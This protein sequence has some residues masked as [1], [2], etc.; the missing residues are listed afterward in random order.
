MGNCTN[1]RDYEM[2]SATEQSRRLRKLE[3]CISLLEDKLDS[4]KLKESTGC[5]M[6]VER[7]VVADANGNMTELV[8]SFL[9]GTFVSFASILHDVRQSL[10]DVSNRPKKMFGHETKAL[11]QDMHDASCDAAGG[12]QK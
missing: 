1:A 6:E 9:W 12:V 3:A 4:L 2:S 10:S 5:D 7:C 8:G 11:Q